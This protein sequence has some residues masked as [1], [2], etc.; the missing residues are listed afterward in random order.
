MVLKLRPS[1]AYA[2]GS[3]PINVPAV[4]KKCTK[5]LGQKMNKTCSYSIL[6]IFANSIALGFK[7][8]GSHQ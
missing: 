8:K 7:N 5:N 6:P 1:A 4:S 2:D 3:P